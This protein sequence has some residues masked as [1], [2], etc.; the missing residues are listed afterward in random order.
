MHGLCI[1]LCV[2]RSGGEQKMRDG[3]FVLHHSKQRKGTAVYVYYMIAWYF[4][5]SGKPF[6]DVI[7]HLGRLDEYQVEFY[8]NSIA[9]LNN[10]PHVFPCKIN[11]VFVRKS[12]EYLGCA[13]GIHFWDYWE[14]STVFERDSDQKDVSTGDIAKILTILRLVKPCSKNFTTELYRETCLP[15][16]VGVSPLSYNKTR[17]FRELENIENQR[18]ELGKHIF[19]FARTKGYTKGELL[20]YDLS[21]GNITGLRCIMAKWGHCKDGYRTHV[22]LMLV[23]TPEAYPIYWE[24]LEGNTA[25]AKTIED[26]VFKIEETYGE[27]ESVICFDR[28]MVSD[29][30][31]RLLEGKNIRFVTAL[32]GNQVKYFQ[33]LIDFPLINR[34][35][36]L[37]IT[38]QSDKIEELLTTGGFTFGGKNLFFKELKLTVKQKKE[39]EKVT[40]KLNLDKRRY[41]L[42]FNPE[43]AYLT[44]KHRKERVEAFKKWIEEYNKELSQ[45]LGDRK[46][47]SIEKSIKDELKRQKIANVDLSYDLSKYKVENK[48]KEGQT[49]K[50]TTYKISLGSVTAKSYKDAMKYDGLWVLLT[51]ISESDDE[52]FF[53]K[54]KFDSF[55]EIYRLKNAIEESFKIL[56]DFVEIEPF[57]V[58]K[59][60]HIKAH[61]TICVLSYLIDTT[62]LNKI[63]SSDEIDSMDLHNVFHS[64]RKCKQ[65]KI[66]LDERMV[67]SQLTQ[68]TEKQ[69]KLLHVLNCSYLVSPKYLA[70]NKIISIDKNRA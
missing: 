39:I 67:V 51:N 9:C 69:K 10:E 54:T 16:L 45:A 20:F 42:T 56:S 2:H 14:L 53:N 24:I 32:D 41:F 49:K 15:Q 38:K 66:Q 5:K 34:V 3:K 35:K 27:I 59:T 65:D 4:R 50:A 21:S 29:E 70:D 13:V 26:L 44:H 55:F 19:N 64:L 46:K 25:D 17:I 28:G 58:Y 31:L 57:Y 30:N 7:K 1:A 6:R 60:E 52:N 48:N 33:D 18:E 43:L 40:K 36:R 23:I 47:E 22:V 11:E 37:N 63:R 12:N 68:L 62:I 8:K 61:F